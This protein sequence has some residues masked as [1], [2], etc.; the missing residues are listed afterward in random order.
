MSVRLQQL[1]VAIVHEW[2]TSMRGGE[3]VVATLLKLFPQADVYALLHK[4]GSVDAIIESRG[5]RTT[6]IDRLPFKNTRYP[7]YLPLFPTAIET[8]NLKDYDL[9]I[10][11]SH[12]VAKGVR[13]GPNTLHISYI[14]T[15]MRYVWDM[16]EN[17]F[18]PQRL[19]WV[20]RRLIPLFANYL[21][22]WDVTSAQRVD[23]FV[24]NSRHVARRVRKFYRRSATVIHPPV[25]TEQFPLS[26]EKKDYYL[27]VTALVPYKR[28]D[29]AIAAA[30][31]KGFPLVVIG[32]GP[33]KKRLQAMA[34]A[35]VRFLPPLPQAE[36]VDYL[37][38]ARALLFPGEEDFG[39]TPIEAQSCGT[40]VIAYGRG[41][42]LETV[43]GHTPGND[44]TAS[45]VFFYRQTVEDL[46]AAIEQAER[47]RWNYAFIHEH[48]QRFHTRFFLEAMEQFILEKWQEHREQA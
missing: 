35:T 24:A 21:R 18:H 10:S 43:V 34:G 11:S 40:P 22:M 14:H 36:M 4:K 42:A 46:V 41:G 23:H 37:Q 26:T 25:E 30:N 45:G 27:V 20:T 48:A 2:F 28:V 15:P 6:F 13:V 44:A 12:C 38:H 33:E 1:K 8:F 17:Y 31:L 47:I 39:I 29:L 5:V 9:V 3:K 16:Y 7:Y 19:N 32:D